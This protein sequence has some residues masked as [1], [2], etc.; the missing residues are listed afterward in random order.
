MKPL[1]RGTDTDLIQIPANRYL[2]DLPSMM[3]IKA[4]PNGS[5]RPQT[6][7]DES[8]AA[9]EGFAYAP[10]IGE[11][12]GPYTLTDDYQQK[13]IE[14]AHVQAAVAGARLAALLNAALAG[15]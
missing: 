6:R 13:A 9:A 15:L 12:D 10:P 3:F 11:G 7:F 14:I 5:C 8:E 2:D 1:V 4:A